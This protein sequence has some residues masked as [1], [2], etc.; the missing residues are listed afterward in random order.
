MSESSDRN[1]RHRE[2]HTQPAAAPS[3]SP[4]RGH[5]HYAGKVGAAKRMRALKRMTIPS[6]RDN[7][8]G[9]LIGRGY[10]PEGP[11]RD[12]VYAG[13]GHRL[14]SAP[15]RA[16]FVCPSLTCALV[17]SSAGMAHHL[18]ATPGTVR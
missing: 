14:L 4:W 2:V 17:K 12:R 15:I 5:Y 3:R 6:D 10:A 18:R 1:F 11:P 9:A 13:R 16:G 8:L 7:I